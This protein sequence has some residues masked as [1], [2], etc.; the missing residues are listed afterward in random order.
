MKVKKMKNNKMWKNEMEMLLTERLGQIYRRLVNKKEIKEVKTREELIEE[1]L[2][3]ILKKE[4]KEGFNL[5]CD[6]EE[7]RSECISKFFNM[8]YKEGFKDAI[9]LIIK[10]T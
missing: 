2:E 6:Y 1:K 4:T 10:N 8:Y 5:Y 7:I 3:K 9:K